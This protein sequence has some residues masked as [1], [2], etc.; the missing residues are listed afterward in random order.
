M[1][2]QAM[3]ISH[4]Y[5]QIPDIEDVTP[6]R[7]RQI[8]KVE[9]NRSV[10]SKLTSVMAIV[11]FTFLIVVHRN[12]YMV[13][14]KEFGVHIFQTTKSRGA[15][16]MEQMTM[17]RLASIFPYISS[18]KFGNINCSDLASS[19]Y[20]CPEVQGRMKVDASKRHQTIVGFGGAFTE[21]TAYNFFKLPQHV[22][23]KMIEMYFG[24]TGIGLT[25]G[26]I[27]INSCDFS[28]ESYSFDDVEGDYALK[29][30]DT[31]VTHDTELI[32][33]LIRLAMSAAAAAATTTHGKGGESGGIK[34]VASPWSP[35][36]W[37][38]VPFPTATAPVDFN[39][40]SVSGDSSRS[41]SMDVSMTGS[42]QPNGLKADE[43]TMNTW[44]KYISKFISAY[45]AHN[46]PI[47][48]LTPQNEPEFAAPWEGC[49]Y[50]ASFESSFI[51]QHL[52]PVMRAEHPD[53]KILAFDHNKDHLL[54]WTE[55][56]MNS[57][58]AEYVDGMAFHCK[59]EYCMTFTVYGP[60]VFLLCFYYVL[61]LIS[62]CL[63]NPYTDLY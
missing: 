61:I 23:D 18:V 52:G 41:I 27:H 53:I 1:P 15:N 19:V 20:V 43:K 36:A 35:P 56:M 12:H 48:A 62:T 14:V 7:D 59:Y 4:G 6:A 8:E 44:A 30:F 55:A 24:S 26:R 32:L 28:L 11:L 33:P 13:D 9:E 37:M 17:N 42:A 63:C 22:Q 51:A 45:K 39:S 2:I 50:N 5:D 54:Q 16:G 38:K 40:S 46:V 25:M 10:V 49:V 31:E 34:L 57:E 3:S 47:W 58:A 21:A 29:Y 60:S